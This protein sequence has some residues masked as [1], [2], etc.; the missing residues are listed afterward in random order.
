VGGA[1]GG[2]DAGVDGALAIVGGVDAAVEG[3]DASSW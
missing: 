1:V 3:E 2:D